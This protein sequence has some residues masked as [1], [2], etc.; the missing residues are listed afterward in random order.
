M[1]WTSEYKVQLKINMITNLP[2]CLSQNLVSLDEIDPF[3]RQPWIGGAIN[4]MIIIAI[5][6]IPVPPNFTTGDAILWQKILAK[7]KNLYLERRFDIVPTKLNLFA[8]RLWQR[9]D[10]LPQFDKI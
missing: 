9:S 2:Y 6:A 8:H 10:I 4:P 3:W 5:N 7:N 1:Q